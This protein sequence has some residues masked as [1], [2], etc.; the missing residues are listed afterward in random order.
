MPP[1]LS[2]G[3]K[4]NNSTCDVEKKKSATPGLSSKTRDERIA[5]RDKW[6]PGCVAR[7]GEEIFPLIPT[8]SRWLR[9]NNRPSLWHRPWT[10]GHDKIVNMKVDLYVQLYDAA[11]N[12]EFQPLDRSYSH[13]TFSILYQKEKK[14]RK[15]KSTDVRVTVQMICKSKAFHTA[16]SILRKQSW[17]HMLFWL[18][19]HVICYL[20]AERDVG[21]SHCVRF[22]M[23][24][25]YYLRRWGGALLPQLWL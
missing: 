8:L 17:I 25:Y 12:A 11:C 2:G 4:S 1:P 23:S 20:L 13:L 7:S 9:I 18:I 15:T 16:V 6:C 22:E 19:T 3:S 24:L 5:H 14:S 21:L 10:P